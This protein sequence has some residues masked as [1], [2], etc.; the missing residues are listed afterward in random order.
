VKLTEA[1]KELE[2]NKAAE[3][4]F[5]DIIDYVS[6]IKDGENE[7][8]DITTLDIISSS[9][10]ECLKFLEDKKK[11]CYDNVNKIS[12]L[13]I[14]NESKSRAKRTT[15]TKKAAPKSKRR[16]KKV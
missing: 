14:K 7:L 1:I 15:S 4:F 6:S 8:F 11:S 13:E 10:E 12:N 9:L 16:S 5:S 3:L 2:K